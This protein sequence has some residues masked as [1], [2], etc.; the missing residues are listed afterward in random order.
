VDERL[1]AVP[2]SRADDNLG[3]VNSGVQV[4]GSDEDRVRLLA[5]RTNGAS[6]PRMVLDT[7]TY[8]EIDDQF[9]LVHVL[10]SPDRVGIEAIYAAPFHNARSTG[11]GDGMR[12]S[13]QEIHRLLGVFGHAGTPVLEGSTEWL[14]NSKVA[15]L[16]PAAQDLIDRAGTGGDDPLY[17]VAIGAPT[18]I[19]SALL[20]APEIIDRVVVIWLGGNSLYWPTAR[21]FNL[22]QDLRASQVLFDSGAALVH[23]PCFNVAD[24]LSTTRAEIEHYARPA[25]KVGAFLADRY[26]EYVEDGAGVSK[27]IWDLAATGW[28]LNPSW[29][30]SELAQSP[31]LTE[32]MTWSRDPDRHLMREVIYVRR[33]AIFGDLFRRLADHATSGNAF[34]T[35]PARD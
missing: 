6:R 2:G 24:H 8:N 18:N 11:P 12:K 32:G 4:R 29:T 33:D 20:L 17:V 27:V 23:V 19:S 26:R 7:D 34:P 28:L 30:T 16:S 25:G 21:E 13:F 5:A 10:L 14:T 35:H 31:I 1:S 9:A 22:K 15:S 3:P